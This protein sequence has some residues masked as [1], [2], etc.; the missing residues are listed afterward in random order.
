MSAAPLWHMVHVAMCSF[1]RF[2][3]R[4]SENGRLCRKEEYGFVS[5]AAHGSRIGGQR[6]ALVFPPL[7]VY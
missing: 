1:H 4:S 6:K 5:G 7:A 2:R 3:N